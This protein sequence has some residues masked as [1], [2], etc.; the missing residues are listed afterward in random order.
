LPRWRWRACDPPCCCRAARLQA[1][2]DGDRARSTRPT[3]DAD[4]RS[5]HGEDGVVRLNDLAPC[6]DGGGRR[7][8]ASTRSQPAAATRPA[9]IGSLRRARTAARD[10]RA[11]HHGRPWHSPCRR[12]IALPPGPRGNGGAAAPRVWKLPRRRAATRSFAGPIPHG[13]RHLSRATVEVSPTARR[14]RR[15]RDADALGHA[16]QRAGGRSPAAAT[17]TPDLPSA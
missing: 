12:R 16:L 5:L 9:C 11:V 17:A 10:R 15:D 4:R 7:G 13:A 3:A 6:R 1:R 2:R 14:R 8:D